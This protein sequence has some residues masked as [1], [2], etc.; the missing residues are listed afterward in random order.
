MP[1]DE[2][3]LNAFVE[4]MLGD[5]GAVFS[6]ALVLLGDKLGLYKAMAESGPIGPQQLALRTHTN[7]RYIREWLSGMAAAG[8]IDYDAATERYTLQPEQAAVLA[9]ENS[10]AF[11]AGAFDIAAAIYRDEPKV[12]AAF[13]SGRG[14]GWHEHS[15][16][17]F[18]GTER[19]FRTSYKHH[20][21]AEWLPA[22]DGVVDKL[23]AGARVADVGCGHGASTI[24]MAQAFPKSHFYGYDYHEASV[25]KARR[26]AQAAGL[27]DRCQF[28]VA[29]ARGYPIKGYDL[30][31]F[32]DCLHDMG[33]PVGAARHVREALAKD[34]TWM[35]VE[36]MAGDTV[37]DNLNPVGR[38]YYAAST[39]IC[40][41][42]SMAQDVGLALGAQAGKERL[43]DVM[44]QGGF[45]RVRV[46]AQT[47]FNLVIEARP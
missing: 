42:A 36:P 13:Q 38:I 28:D 32:F 1:L 29:D 18:S 47:P 15:Q 8:Y 26:E 4:K 34:G 45:S 33:D 7:E 21:V 12:E 27:G 16:C 46:A 6:G 14:L 30:I 23:R 40:T 2:G 43:F 31:V 9:D 35:V 3:K 37:Q 25:D 5:M 19:F 41:P 10:P 17:L 44:R 22:L 11:M 39:M 24:I 20:L